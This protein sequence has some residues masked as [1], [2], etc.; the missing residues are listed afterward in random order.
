MTDSDSEPLDRLD[1]LASAALDGEADPA[2]AAGSLS[3]GDQEVFRDRMAEFAR[4]REEVAEP[5]APPS[6]E[7]RDR[8]IARAISVGTA[9]TDAP[10]IAATVAP[11]QSLDEHRARRAMRLR[12][13][14]P[15]AV[16]AA[17]VLLLGAVALPSLLDE[18]EENL[19]STFDEGGADMAET[20]GDAE[21]ATAPSAATSLFDRSLDEADTEAM[22]EEMASGEA[23]ATA[24]AES[25]LA[26]PDPAESGD[27]TAAFSFDKSSNDELLDAVIRYRASDPPSDENV[28][29]QAL[30][31]ACDNVRHPIDLVIDGSYQSQAA[32]FVIDVDGS[33]VLAV[34]VLNPSCEILAQVSSN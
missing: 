6:E 30:R 20:G 17:A 27:G 25:A 32:V 12:R 9:T 24:D 34:T 13:F 21:A 31:N 11:V 16:A 19:A 7:I 22:E 28:A 10:A 15:V 14:A 2:I 4:V 3:D 5:P 29:G 23:S 18:G 33:A 26:V 8:M 1:D